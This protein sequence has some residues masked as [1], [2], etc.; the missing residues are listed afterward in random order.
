MPEPA[1]TGT[2]D[3]T[4]WER[5]L[6]E[7]VDAARDTEREFETTVRSVR[8]LEAARNEIS[9]TLKRPEPPTIVTLDEE[10]RLVQHV[11]TTLAGLAK[12]QTQAKRWQ[13]QIAERGAT[14]RNLETEVIS[15]PSNLVYYLAWCVAAFGIAGATWRYTEGDIV[16]LALLAGGSLICAIGAMVQRRLRT[17]AQEEDAQRRAQLDAAREELERACQSLLHHQERASR[18][19]FDISVDSVRLGLPPMPTDLQL[20][21]REAEVEAQRRQRTEWDKA[22]ATLAEHLSSL[23]AKE[24]LRRQQAQALMAA[25]GHERQTVQQ[26]NQWKVHA[27]LAD[28]GS[29]LR[30]AGENVRTEV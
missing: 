7:A 8:E 17:Q 3:L 21:E 16:G 20:K 26:W 9:A 13:D 11:R 22:Q 28:N 15:I 2:E 19:R 1:T 24:E 27:G 4:G 14:I 23:A 30:G 29:A 12:E 18:R 5:R 10:A 6:K 25:Q